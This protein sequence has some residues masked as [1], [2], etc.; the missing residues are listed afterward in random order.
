MVVKFRYEIISGIPPEQIQEYFT[1]LSFEDNRT[2]RFYGDG[3]EINIIYEKDR[4]LGSIKLPVTRIVF[5]GDKEL[6][7]KIISDFRMKF[8]SAGG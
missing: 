8:L 4:F 2:N 1:S 7:E 6:C 3:W 5:I